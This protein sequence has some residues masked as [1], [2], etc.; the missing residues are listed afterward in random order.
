M[1]RSLPQQADRTS[2]RF[3]DTP[4]GI[5]PLGNSHPQGDFGPWGNTTPRGIQPLREYS[6]QWNSAPNG[7]QPPMEFS[8][9]WHSAPKGASPILFRIYQR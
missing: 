4:N 1:G 8:P 2:T 5:S 9:Q 6:P 7:I 3:Q